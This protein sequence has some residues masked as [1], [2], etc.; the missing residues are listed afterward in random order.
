VQFAPEGA[1]VLEEDGTPGGL[2]RVLQTASDRQFVVL[3][4]GER[5]A[6]ADVPS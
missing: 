5:V 1:V 2:R 4:G 3:R 6:P